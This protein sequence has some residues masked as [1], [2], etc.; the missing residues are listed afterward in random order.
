MGTEI[1]CGDHSG[2]FWMIQFLY[3][4]GQFSSKLYDGIQAL[5]TKEMLV[6]GQM[7]SDCSS[8]VDQMDV[9]KM[10]KKNINKALF[11][12]FCLFY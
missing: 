6:S 8:L 7:S 9:S 11:E 3:G 2:P 5:C 12:L 1:L 4:H 10:K